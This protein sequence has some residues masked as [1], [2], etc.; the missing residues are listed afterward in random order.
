MEKVD[1]I[2]SGIHIKYLRAYFSGISDHH[3]DDTYC[4]G[5]SCIRL[6][7]QDDVLHGLI[8]L[9]RTEIVFE[10]EAED[11]ERLML[12]YRMEFLSAGG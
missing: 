12:L 5:H 7:P 10:G 6:I 11:V 3:R 2:L 1:S 8:A 9:P 4:C